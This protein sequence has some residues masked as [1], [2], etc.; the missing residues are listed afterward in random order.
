MARLKTILVEHPERGIF[1]AEGVR[2]PLEAVQAAAKHWGVQWSMVARNC[3]VQTEGE[4]EFRV[5]GEQRGGGG[6]G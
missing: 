4:A 6:S 2:N 3:R 1:A 5:I